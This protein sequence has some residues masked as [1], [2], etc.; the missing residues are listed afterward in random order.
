MARLTI[1]NR[2]VDVPAGGTIL[3]GA[4]ALG[5]EIPTLCFREGVEHFGS[6]MVCVV[7]EMN[8][9][10]LIPSCSAVAVDGMVIETA[11]NEVRDS[12]KTA[13]ELLLGDHVGDC[14]APCRR[15][16]PAHMNIPLMIRQI[17][18]GKLRDAIITVKKDIALPAVLGRIC[19]APCE[20]GCRRSLY[21]GPVAIRLLKRFAAD[22][23][24]AAE[25]PWLPPPKSATGRKVAVIGAGPAG[26]ATAYYLLQ[27]GHACTVFDDH[28]KPGGMLRLGVDRERLPEGVLD[29]EIETIAHLGA[30]FR[31]NTKVG[32]DV[33]IE[34][35]QRDFDAL[36]IAVGE[37][38][39]G[40]A[41]AFGVEAA[42][43]GAK[44]N[45][46]T[47]QA[48]GGAVFA[49]GS[50]VQPSRLAVRAVADGKRAA[51]SLS[52]FLADKEVNAPGKRFDSKMGPLIEGEI[53]EFAK[54]NDA[55]D[56]VVPSAAGGGFSLDEAVS[57]AHR[58]LHCDCRKADY[59]A[60]RRYADEY[61]ARQER[62]RGTERRE[63]E[64]ILQHSDVVYEPGKCI[65]CGLCVRITRQAGERLGLTFIG[66]GFDLRIGVPFDESFAVGLEKTAA[67]CVRAC[68]SGA[69]SFKQEEV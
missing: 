33:Q 6:C 14:E 16:C 57:Q 9:G 43:H 13:L 19:P 20:K 51:A 46:A 67:E 40:A 58:C 15:I 18:A 24:L 61:Q 66:R 68:P 69:L 23:D 38:A 5:I 54:E 2:S 55:A 25:S 26:L 49:A 48:A 10:R 31:M 64:R 41:A 59:C 60:L 45:P 35:L 39:D 11:N 3:D 29:A 21:D 47:L 62:Y 12:R 65:K 42:M 44:V 50:A 32:R 30:D 36:V 63:F 8:S 53:D 37:I 56:L 1:D 4:R 22:T 17:A 52:Q 27:E 28:D 7:Q 34:D